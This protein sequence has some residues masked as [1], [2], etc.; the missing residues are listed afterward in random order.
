MTF[1]LVLASRESLWACADRRLTEPPPR[2][3]AKP[4]VKIT[5]I[6]TPDALMRYMLDRQ[7]PAGARGASWEE[8]GG[9]WPT[10]TATG[11]AAIQ[12]LALPRPLE[13]LRQRRGALSRVLDAEQEA[14][15]RHAGAALTLA[16]Q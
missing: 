7:S 8:I 4:V 1:A 11:T 2:L 12:R 10:L 14:E 15:C 6:S 9:S 16:H 13:P 5:I 3:G